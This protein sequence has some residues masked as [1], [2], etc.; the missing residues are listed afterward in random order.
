MNLQIEDDNEEVVKFFTNTGY[1][2]E[3]KLSMGK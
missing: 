1:E 3:E 2:V